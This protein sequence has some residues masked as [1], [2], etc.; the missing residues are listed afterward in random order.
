ME[1][2]KQRVV[3][4]MR[5]TGK[6]H[7]GHYHG[8]LTN[9]IKLQEEY[10]CLFFVADWH[11]LTTE[12]SDPAL[13]PQATRELVV[14]WLA[15]G[16]DPKRSILFIQSHIKEHA[17]LFLLL[18]MLMP[19][20]W[21]ERVPSYKEMQQELKG[22]D[23]STYGFLGYPLLQAADI[24][25]YNAHKV[26]IG[27]D[28]APHIEMTRELVRRF[29]HLY[30][31]K[32][33]VEPQS[34]MT[35]APKLLGPDRRK[36]SKSYDN[37]LYLSDSSKDIEKKVMTSITDP[38]RQRREDP[39]NP[40]I[41]LIFDYHK[42]HSDKKDVK[43]IDTECRKA[44]IGCVACK[45]LAAKNINTLLDKIRVQREVILSCPEKID[46]ILEEGCQKARQLAVTSMH[47]VREAL[48]L[49]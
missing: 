16:L 11:A 41:C 5:P 39:G 22:K 9:W 35:E 34:L 14:D 18:A 32:V 30:K 27:I 31:K 25:I 46:K 10:E 43:R 26:P 38:A 20:G 1:Q 29:N 15:C 23:L 24:I 12:Y 19:L 2:K 13:I 36:M 47:K 7:L 49:E 17:E 33:F 45:Q 48:K 21:L 40:E 4:G 3:S 44:E 8:V 42:L 28:Q 37:C 6:L